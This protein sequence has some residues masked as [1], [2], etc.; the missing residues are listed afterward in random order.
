[1]EIARI[2]ENKP[3]SKIYGM[4]GNINITTNNFN[5]SIVTPYK[6]KDTVKD[7]LN[8]NKDISSLKMVML[9]ETYLSKK[10]YEL[11]ENEIKSIN[12]AKALI[13]NKEYIILD[14]FEKGLNHKEK[15]SFKRL[16]KKLA[17]DYNKTILLFTNDLSFIW[18]IAEEIIIVDNNEVINTIQKNQIFV[19]IEFLDKPEIIKF[20]DLIRSKGIIIENYKDT[21]DL[22]K[23]IYRIKDV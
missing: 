13:E 18:D 11:S 10:S 9:D 22:L 14:Y 20:I 19:I 12:L 16:F 15:E 2:L 3:K 6:F 17:R 8:S 4:L 5:Y 21:M 7:Y 1:M 23:A